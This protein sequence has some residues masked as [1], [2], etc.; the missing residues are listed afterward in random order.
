M[1]FSAYAQVV[2]SS[3]MPKSPQD[4]VMAKNYFVFFL[5][6][7][8]VTIVRDIVSKNP[9]LVNILKSKKDAL[10][11]FDNSNDVLAMVERYKWSDS[12]I[13]I[14]T[15]VL[16]ANYS[17][18][19]KTLVK[20]ELLPSHK[21][22]VSTGIS[23]LAY[24]KK[25]LEQDFKAM[26]YAIDVYAGGKKPNYP[27]IDSISF[28]INK[29]S[30]LSTL[31]DVRQDVLK[32]INKDEDIFFL[33]LL[34][35]VRFLEINERWDASLLEPLVYNENKAAV[36]AAS[37]MD[38]NKYPYASLLVLGAGPDQYHQPISPGGMLRCR[39]AARTYKSGLAPFIIVSGGRVH[40]YKT[41]YI[42]A[43]EMK[44]YLVETHGI[45]AEAVIIDPHAR[46][47]TTNLRNASRL[48]LAYGFPKDKF[49]IVGSSIQHIDAV[50]NMA[51]RCMKEL[52]CVPYNLGKRV[53]DVILE[54][55]PALES[56]IIDWDEPLDP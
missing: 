13:K 37:K 46:H 47:T 1:Q 30:Y 15:D 50:A 36:E 35:A 31:K 32:D 19:L 20:Q 9:N 16:L 39:M 51:G 53:S 11:E 34:S 6:Y 44:K 21:Y 49:S 28:D 7:K 56:L 4:W 54:F 40:P 23:D 41:P 14:L 18:N 3:F 27:R 10:A 17:I 5:L 8:D 55:K 48:L 12:E 42:E 29:K 45:P 52:G 22:G 43:I 24:L 26:N 33:S 2:S 25:S 38:W